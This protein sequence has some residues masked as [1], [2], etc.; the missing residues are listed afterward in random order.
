[1]TLPGP[2][3]ATWKT[4][5][6]KSRARRRP[7][8]HTSHLGRFNQEHYAPERARTSPVDLDKTPEEGLSNGRVSLLSGGS[9]I[10][11]CPSAT[12]HARPIR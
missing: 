9:Q 10:A 11:P 1:M 4:R 3:H 2:S 8:E 7:E 6:P 5:R 12:A